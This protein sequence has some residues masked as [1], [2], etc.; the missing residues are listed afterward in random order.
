[1]KVYIV[2]FYPL[3]MTSCPCK[4]KERL[5]S[6]VLSAFDDFFAHVNPMKVYIVASYPWLMIF[7]NVNPMKV[8]LVASYPLL[9]TSSPCKSNESLYSGVLSA[10]DAFLPM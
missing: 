9:M 4:S 1:M 6:G 10:V 3:L 8:Y 2:T 5:Y 7:A